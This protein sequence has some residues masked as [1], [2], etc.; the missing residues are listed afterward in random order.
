[1]LSQIPRGPTSKR[2]YRVQGG[3][4]GRER[5]ERVGKGERE[6]KEKRKRK[7]GRGKG[8]RK[9]KRRGEWRVRGSRLAR[10]ILVCLRRR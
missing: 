2:R 10:P 3:K 7:E 8:G 4:E 1:V 9:G 6:G 5:D